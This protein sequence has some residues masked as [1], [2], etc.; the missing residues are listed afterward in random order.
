MLYA[1][2]SQKLYEN[3]GRPLNIARLGGVAMFKYVSV[4]RIY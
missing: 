4:T 2:K 3:L 1:T